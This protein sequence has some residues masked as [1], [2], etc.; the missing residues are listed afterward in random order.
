MKNMETVNGKE[1]NRE[2]TDGTCNEDHLDQ[3]MRNRIIKSAENIQI[4]EQ[5]NPESVKG[6]LDR[7]QKEA[8][9]GNKFKSKNRRTFY[10]NLAVAACLCLC[11]GGTAFSYSYYNKNIKN[12]ADSQI[13]AADSSQT[14]SENS[15]NAASH[16]DGQPE[17]GSS[18]EAVKQEE[19][20][21]KKLGKFYK[22]AS[23]YR[24]VYNALGKIQYGLSRSETKKESDVAEGSAAAED[25]AVKN[26]YGFDQMAENTKDSNSKDFSTTN[27][28]V[29]GVDES[30]AVKTDGKYIYVVQEE[31]IKILDAQGK[32]LKL[33]ATLKPEVAESLDSICEIY[34]ADNVLTVVL[35]ADKPN[36]KA[37]KMDG[38]KD[39][40]QD[41]EFGV[42]HDIVSDED[43]IRIN[44]DVITKVLT[45]DI[46]DPLHPALL[47]T[48]E[49]DGYYQTSRKIENHLYLFT[50]KSMYIQ[51]GAAQK[52]LYAD[53]RAA[54]WKW[55]PCING[56]AIRPD[57]IYLPNEEGNQG[58][59]MT[60]LDL[61]AHCNVTDTT[62][63]VN[64]GGQLYVTM[65]SAYFYSSEY[66]GDTEKTKIVRFALDTDGKIR[67]KAAAVVKGDV[68]DT[69]ALDESDG[70]L[71]V[72]TSLTTKEPWENRVYVIRTDDMK[73][74]GKLTGIAK[75]EMIYAA[76]F[77][78]TTGYFV[79]YRNTDPL[80]TVDFSNPDNPKLIG[81]LAVT[82]FSEY[83]HFWSDHKLLGIGY[84]TNPTNGE[85]IGVK[86]SMYDIS[87]P[88]NVVEQAKTVLQDTDDSEAMYDYKSVL[89]DR[90]KNLVAFTTHTYAA[91]YHADY[92]V[93]SFKNG[94]FT[95]NLR[96]S[97][98]SD[99]CGEHLR[100]LYIGDMLYLV[101]SR[102]AIAFCMPEQFKETGKITY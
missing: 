16:A 59:V 101:G 87:N 39:E 28:Q 50:N 10:R 31:K 38:K 77:V 14:K 17:Q 42:E 66:T 24:E 80:F 23:D 74:A 100:S 65:G 40:A 51:S 83:L 55:I 13:E 102:K 79:T 4:P 37:E 63:L 3:D 60:C 78:G 19:K 95:G 1:Q 18:D 32:E 71:R 73:V 44:Y 76:R 53:D 92:H 62:M 85:I 68:T 89:I 2:N 8:G 21:V 90:R 67:A 49:Q 99:G 91:Q 97:L 52:K 26:S 35:Q 34:V 9:P 69:F 5:L 93:F 98:G 12:S 94:E 81:E 82:G 11:F 27:L 96:R 64:Q 48:V 41:G 6:G 84:E 20:Q 47:D 56:K 43:V 36:I 46:T 25:I 57:C 45:Y 61:A 15:K 22:L 29:A 86:L 7:R 88:K 72:L 58:V 54:E 70:Y 30:D 75:G 33:A